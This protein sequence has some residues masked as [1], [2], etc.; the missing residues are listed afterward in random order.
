MKTLYEKEKE[1]EEKKD[2]IEERLIMGKL[3]EKKA[4]ELEEQINNEI[5][6]IRERTRD[7]MDDNMNIENEGN[8]IYTTR[9]VNI[10]YEELNKEQRYDIVHT[11]IDKVMLK[12]IERAI[13]EIN[14]YNKIDNKVKTIE[15]NTFKRKK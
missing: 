11:V 15:V 12:R 10:N 9:D 4:D 7:I 5:K 14:I 13:L 3:S 8:R 6:D 2:K 1:L